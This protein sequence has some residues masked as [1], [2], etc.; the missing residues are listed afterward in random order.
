MATENLQSEDIPEAELEGVLDATRL[1]CGD[2][3]VANDCA[4]NGNA[5]EKKRAPIK[6]YSRDADAMLDNPIEQVK[7]DGGEGVDMI[8]F[9]YLRVVSSNWRIVIGQVAIRSCFCGKR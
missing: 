2:T 6:P 5:F 7:T 9:I 4:S 8:I 1:D 3:D